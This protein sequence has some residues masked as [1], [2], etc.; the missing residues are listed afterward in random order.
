VRLGFPTEDNNKKPTTHPHKKMRLGFPTTPSPSETVSEPPKTKPPKIVIPSRLG[1][2]TTPHRP[3]LQRPIVSL[4]PPINCIA[5]AET[6]LPKDL[7][8]II[9]LSYNTFKVTFTCIES[10]LEQTVHP[11]E[12]FVVDNGSRDGTVDWLRTQKYLTLIANQQNLGYSTANNLAIRRA[13]GEY[14]CL[15]NSDIIVRT[16]GWLGHMVNVAKSSPLVGTVGAKLLYPDN[17]IQHIGG[18]IHESSPYHPYDKHPANTKVAN[19][20]VPYNTGACLLI[21]RPAL[22][23]V[24]LLDETY[25]FGFEDVDYGLRVVEKG[26]KNIVCHEA[27]LTHLWAYTQRTTGKG[28][29]TSS[30]SR[31]HVKWDNKL[32]ALAKKI[33]LDWGAPY[34]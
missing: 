12:L 34:A 26:L 5:S 33:T 8:S 10:V 14:V 24:G 7:V 1:F 23:M 29:T 13:R 15:L 25:P 11:F 31:F 21:T 3:K 32:P 27:V 28:L 30:L 18:G 20:D 19:R 6:E 2:P 22:N 4:N 16:G 9:I 17:K